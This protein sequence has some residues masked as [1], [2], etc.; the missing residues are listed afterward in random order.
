MIKILSPRFVDNQ[1][2]D[3]LMSPE[4]ILPGRFDHFRVFGAAAGQIALLG[5][6]QEVRVAVF[7]KNR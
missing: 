6:D 3:F 2:D 7:S 1:L 4:A 5:G